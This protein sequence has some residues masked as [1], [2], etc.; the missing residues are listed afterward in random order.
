MNNLHKYLALVV[1]KN[2]LEFQNYKPKQKYKHIK[3]QIEQNFHSVVFEYAIKIIKSYNYNSI[4][5]DMIKQSVNSF[6]M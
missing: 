4:N 1:Q 2:E 3:G 5:S 6:Y